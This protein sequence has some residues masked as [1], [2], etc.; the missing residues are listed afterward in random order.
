M[1]VRIT[2]IYVRTCI[3]G[4]QLTRCTFNGQQ[5]CSEQTLGFFSG[6]VGPAFFNF[7][8]AFNGARTA[9]NQLRSETGGT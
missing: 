3:S 1:Y 7:D 8:G 2:C 6:F 9:I 5:C 4:S